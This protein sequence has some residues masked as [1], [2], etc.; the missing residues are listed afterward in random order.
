MIFVN[1]YSRVNVDFPDISL[2]YAATHFNVPVVDFNTN[3]RPYDA[4]LSRKTDT[5]GISVRSLN[6]G[7]AARI[8]NT[9]KSAY[10][11]TKVVSVG[12]GIDIQC[13]YPYRKWDDH[14]EYTVEFSDEYPFPNYELFDTFPLFETNW[15]NGV[16]R[17]AIMTSLGCPFP[18]EHCMCRSRKFRPRSPENSVNELRAAVDRWKIKKFFIL[19]D[20]FNANKKRAIRFCR[21]VK[22]LCLPWEC[23]NGLRA[24]LFDDELAEALARAG[25]VQVSF[26]IESTD[27]DVLASI[28]KAESF[29]QMEKAAIIAR[30][31][32][33]NVNGFFIIGLPG[34]SYKSDRAG[35]DWARRIGINAH[36]SYYVPQGLNLPDDEVF[37]GDG[38]RPLSD[39]Y[40]AEDQVRLFNETSAMRPPVPSV[41]GAK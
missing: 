10:P 25:C 36:F 31:Y 7:E 32:F 17:Y 37:Y 8:A 12:S 13:C 27:N 18:C 15:K 30:R 29:E 19:D 14:L 28:N 24:D 11:N 33:E 6:A 3:P 16:W 35:L 22:D 2:A 4:L 23:A 39:A 21:L 5:L 1:P 34:S 41:T 40:P 20:C 26:G 38:A 9:Y